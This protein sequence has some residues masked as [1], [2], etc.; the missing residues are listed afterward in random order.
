[1]GALA[2]GGV[3]GWV[4]VSQELLGLCVIGLLAEPVASLPHP[5]LRPAGCLTQGWVGMLCSLRVLV[6]GW[7]SYAPRLGMGASQTS[8][9]WVDPRLSG[10]V[11]GENGQAIHSDQLHHVSM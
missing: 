2:V 8:V 4:A 10:L 11:T 5:Q 7:R 3:T 6:T 9:S 1:M